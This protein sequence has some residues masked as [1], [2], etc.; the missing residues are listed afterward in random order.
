[1]RDAMDALSLPSL[2]RLNEVLF[3]DEDDGELYLRVDRGPRKAG[4]IAGGRNKTGHITIA[5]DGRRYLAHRVIW[6][7][8]TGN[9]PVVDID[10]KDTN[11]INNRFANLREATVGQNRHNMRLSKRNTSGVKGVCFNPKLGKWCVS[12]M[13]DLVSHRIGYFEKFED[14]KAAAGAARDRLHGEFA[15]AA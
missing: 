11:G 14:A 2:E 3:Y 7:I 5:I 12:I 6:K 13:K 9:D 10:H 15:R 1:M 4:M 8:K